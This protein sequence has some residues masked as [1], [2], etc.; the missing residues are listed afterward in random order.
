MLLVERRAV[1]NGAGVGAD[2]LD[3]EVVTVMEEQFGEAVERIV[4]PRDAAPDVRGVQ[5]IAQKGELTREGPAVRAARDPQ[6]VL[7]H[8]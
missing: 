6:S 7:P 4:G 8:R 5:A 2:E 1:Q 3:F